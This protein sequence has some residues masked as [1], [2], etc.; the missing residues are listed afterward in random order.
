M[1]RRCCRQ[2]C[3]LSRSILPFDWPGMAFG[4][5]GM[6][7]AGNR[8][9]APCQ[10][11]GLDLRKI[12][13]DAA[14]RQRETPRKVAALL[15]LVDRAVG[16]GHHLSQLVPPDGLPDLQRLALTHSQSPSRLSPAIENDRCRYRKSLL[17]GVRQFRALA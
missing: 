2:S 12:P 7:S 11:P 5:I 10:Q 9:R 3:R 15:Q 14:R 8:F 6:L 4:H 1:F 16:Q 13:D 17:R